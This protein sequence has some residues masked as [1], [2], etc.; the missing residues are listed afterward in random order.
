MKT[1]FMTRTHYTK[2]IAHKNS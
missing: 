1:L 2:D